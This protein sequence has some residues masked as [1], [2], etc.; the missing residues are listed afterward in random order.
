MVFH[1][2]ALGR[3]THRH[4]ARHALTCRRD[5][6]LKQQAEHEEPWGEGSLTFSHVSEQRAAAVLPKLP[7][8]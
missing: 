1:V 7:L 4:A 8:D 3:H 2:H 5:E 6:A